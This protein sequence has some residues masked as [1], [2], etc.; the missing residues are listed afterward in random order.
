M[1]SRQSDSSF[2]NDGKLLRCF[3]REGPPVCRAHDVPLPS[4]Q[5][6]AT[7]VRVQFLLRRPA[8]PEFRSVSGGKGAF[9][10]SRIELG[11]AGEAGRY[12]HGMGSSGPRVVVGRAANRWGVRLKVCL[13]NMKRLS[14]ILIHVRCE[15][16]EGGGSPVKVPPFGFVRDRGILAPF[17]SCPLCDA[18]ASGETSLFQV[19]ENKSCF[20]V[21]STSQLKDG[22]G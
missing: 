9:S 6:H 12:S 4:R 7:H 11:G 17:H 22:W 5:K 13:Q 2:A 20:T 14:L 16:I 1:S 8:V 15:V 10:T 21:E 3:H 19:L 18:A